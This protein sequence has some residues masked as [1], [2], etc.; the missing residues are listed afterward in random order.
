MRKNILLFFA[1]LLAIFS[2][3][4]QTVLADDEYNTP[5]P[6]VAIV[7]LLQ[8]LQSGGYYWVNKVKYEHGAYELK[9]LNDKGSKVTA[10]LNSDVAMLPANLPF[11]KIQPKS[12][13]EVTMLQ[14]V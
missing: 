9:G 3:H 1:G 10:S 2:M 11:S 5:P 13:V 14:A 6:K 8:K 7:D 4:A 12:P